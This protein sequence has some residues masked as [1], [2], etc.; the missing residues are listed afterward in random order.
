MI[1]KIINA[2]LGLLSAFA[3]V[4][5]IVQKPGYLT[6]FHLTRC[7]QPLQQRYTQKQ[8]I[9]M[10]SRMLFITVLSTLPSI[11]YLIKKL[12][13]MQLLRLQG[14][15]LNDRSNCKNALYCA[16]KY[17]HRSEPDTITDNREDNW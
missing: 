9:S 7:V 16:I 12:E 2:I 4:A 1:L 14:N 5:H 13:L 6:T 8:K 10:Q 17:E 15:C 11:T 3:V